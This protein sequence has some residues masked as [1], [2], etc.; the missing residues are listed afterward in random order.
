MPVKTEDERMD[1]S[2]SSKAKKENIHESAHEGG[3][4]RVQLDFSPAAFARLEE[5]RELAGA[6][7]NSEVIR[8]SVRVYEWFLRQKNDGFRINLIKGDQAKE[9]ELLI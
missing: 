7:T 4:Q 8:N 6:K 5:I 1:A 3:R 2:T 9:V